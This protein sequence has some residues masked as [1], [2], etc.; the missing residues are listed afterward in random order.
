[1]DASRLS[2][3][4]ASPG[5][6]DDYRT[7]A[8][9]CAGAL[10]RTLAASLGVELDL[11][12][13]EDLPPAYG[14]PQGVINPSVDEA[15]VL[16]AILGRRLGSPT[17]V[18]ESGFVEEFE[19]MATRAR[20]GEDVAILTYMQEL[21]PEELEDPGEKLR[22]VLAFRER[23][24]GEVLFKQV[25]SVDHFATEL[26]RDLTVL[27]AEAGERVRGSEMASDAS[28][29]GGQA[30]T[31]EP[32]A[33]LAAGPAAEQ[34]R[35]L[36]TEAAE[37]AP[38]VPERFGRERFPLARLALWLSTW[39]SWFFSSETLGIHQQNRIFLMRDEVALGSAEQRQILRGICAEFELAPGWALLDVPLAD[40]VPQLLGLLFGEGPD[41]V[42]VGALRLLGREAFAAWFGRQ[43]VEL[44]PPDFFAQLRTY[45]EGASEPVRAGMVD[46]AIRIGGEEGRTF[47]ADLR[48]VGIAPKAALEGSIRLAAASDP[49]LAFGLAATAD[50]DLGVETLRALREASSG[51]SREVLKAL[52]SAPAEAT[53]ILAAELLKE[54]GEEAVGDMRALLADPAGAVSMVA[55]DSLAALADP[56]TDLLQAADEL[57]ERFGLG[58]EPEVRLLLARRRS[59]EELLDQISWTQPATAAAY[60]VLAERDFDSFGANV[61][62]DLADDFEE[63]AAEAMK[64]ALDEFS[65]T[66]RALLTAVPAEDA[67]GELGEAQDTIGQV[68]DYLRGGDWNRRRFTVAALRG[69]AVVGEPADGDLVRDKLDAEELELRQEAAAALA[70]VGSEADIPR[71]LELA[72]TRTGEP[73]A[74]AAIAIAPGPEGAARKLLLGSRQISTLL[75]ARHLYTHAAK[76]SEETIEA[77]L[78][79][80]QDGVRRCGVAC[81][82][83]RVGEDVAALEGLLDA[84]VSADS[85]YYDV[86]SLLDVLLFAP[87][88]LGDR[89]RADLAAFAAEERSAPPI[90][91]HS[92]PL[93]NALLRSRLT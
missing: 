41:P 6:L 43:D 44:E 42:R 84:Y 79:H 34:L 11:V 54:H 73:F 66:M 53:R 29:P 9:E 65:P 86:V 20:A 25:R 77:M 67:E 31:T 93:F 45:A 76:L 26:T 70:R 88:Y 16:V 33:E 59:S 82:L 39:E 38:Q 91:R 3:F 52:G 58:F 14:R 19:R 37:A 28:T 23:L 61:R 62:R 69:I 48:E 4:L 68:R 13:W 55:F 92:E 36:L 56:G 30:V 57:A 50:G 40:V 90:K 47:L 74:A 15:N 87:H 35:V 71:L 72:E 83:V 63:F 51:A 46:L 1:M 22:A 5:G 24:Q 17:G 85:Y 49:V 2:L 12:G 32:E 27:V 7:A 60:Q 80:S 75:A 78:R 89:T 64:R 21:P 18:A 81:A 10:R 8:R